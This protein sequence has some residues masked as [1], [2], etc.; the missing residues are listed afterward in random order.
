M[1]FIFLSMFVTPVDPVLS[2][3]N[4]PKP[5][6]QSCYTFEDFVCSYPCSGQYACRIYQRYFA[7]LCLICGILHT[8]LIC[9]HSASAA[10]AVTLSL[11]AVLRSCLDSGA[12]VT[13]HGWP[14]YA[15][16]PH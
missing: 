13:Q 6:T 3:N 9:T 4:T 16:S 8:S 11:L 12:V 14:A 7:T 5:S 2:S 15:Q 10:L 1:K